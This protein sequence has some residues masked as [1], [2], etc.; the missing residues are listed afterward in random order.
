MINLNNFFKNKYVWYC[1][2]IAAI[3]IPF[4]IGL[5]SIVL[6]S[7]PFWYDPA[8][9]FLLAL[10]NL[11][12][13]TL[14]GPT[15]GIPGIFYGPH[16]IWLLSF[17]LLFS[18]DPRVVVF[19]IQ[20]IPY[21]LLAPL[22]LLSLLTLAPRRVLVV[23]WIFFVL[24]FGINYATFPWNPHAAPFLFILLIFLITKIKSHTLRRADFV[25]MGLCGGV[26]GTLLNVH[27]SFGIGLLI[28]FLVY[29]CIDTLIVTRSHKEFIK[30]RVI[31]LL[32]FGTGLGIAL[33]PFFIFEARHGFMQTQTLIATLTAGHSVVAVQGL[34]KLGIITGFFG[35]ILVLFQMPFLVFAVVVLLAGVEIFSSLRHKRFVASDQEKKVWLLLISTAVAVLAIY[36]SSKNPVWSYHFIAVDVIFLFVAILVLKRTRITF[37]IMAIWSVIILFM[38]T[39]TFIKSFADDPLRVS[40]LANKEYVVKQIARDAGNKPYDIFAFSPSIYVYD[41]TYLFKYL[42]GKDVP[43]DPGSSESHA[44]IV[45]II[46]PPGDKSAIA[47]FIMFRTPDRVYM[48]GKSWSLP[49]GTKVLKRERQAD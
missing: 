42:A 32:C 22:I 49:D 30:E 14:I 19:I 7:F 28:G 47:D 31:L 17:G 15:S 9:D 44:E 16:W 36:L 11:G 18:R 20:T 12:K 29:L 6:G 26:V 21:L 8:R 5:R 41:Y 45:Y 43:Y 23:V 24:N 40:S 33:A 38:Q 4:I 46:L 13:L 34:S 3:G 27:I 10:G 25:L 48:T 39:G 37:M 1:I 2:Y 35:R